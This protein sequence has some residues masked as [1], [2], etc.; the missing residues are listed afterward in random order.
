MQKTA[1]WYIAGTVLVL[2]V[3]GFAKVGASFG[4]ARILEEPDPLVLV[5]SNRQVMLLAAA[6]EAIVIGLLLREVSVHRRVVLI[7]WISS[8][9]LAYRVGLWGIGYGG[10]CSCLGHLTD[11]LG[12]STETADLASK[13]ILGYLLLGS[14]TVLAWAW[15]ARRDLGRTVSPASAMKV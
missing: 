1:R 7:A 3:T 5:L 6:M 10:S 14:Y 4:G 13:L 15:I 12:I 2:A 8:V 11:A 9:F